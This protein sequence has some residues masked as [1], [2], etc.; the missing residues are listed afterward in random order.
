MATEIKLIAQPRDG[1]GTP[2]TF[3]YKPGAKHAAESNNLYK[4]VV[5]GNADLPA[6]TKIVRNG[7]SVVFNFPDGTHFEIDNWCGVT[8]SRLTDL[9]N[10]QA[11]SNDESAYVNAKEIESGAC[12]IWGDGGQAAAVLG[13]G[14]SSTVAAG[15]A[16][17]AGATSS[18]GHGTAI[19][20]VGG[21]LGVGI[22]AAVAGQSGDKNTTTVVPNTNDAPLN[23]VPL[24]VVDLGDDFES[25]VKDGLVVAVNDPD[26]GSPDD[27]FKLASVTISVGSDQ[28]VFQV[29]QGVNDPVNVTG[30]GTS[31]L[32]LEGTQADMNNLLQTLKY[33]D[34]FNVDPQ[35]PGRDIIVTVTSVDK[36]GATDTDQITLR[37][38]G[39]GG[40]SVGGGEPI[41]VTELFSTEPAPSATTSH[42]APASVSLSSLI[43]DPNDPALQAA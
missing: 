22:L 27:N 11:Y 1:S 8:D 43:G 42:A 21:L 6:G 7:N 20:I 9:T 38:Q 4:V 39:L 10:A 37:V 12:M 28:G 17:A 33:V 23:V 41:G 36:Q 40:S 29:T 15:D 34:T 25:S 26:E 35:N 31:L 5:D 18:D 32:R 14:S 3:D 16:G 19:G 24:N 2:K 13:D 30:N